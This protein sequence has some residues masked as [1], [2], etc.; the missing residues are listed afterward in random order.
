MK[1]LLH[2]DDVAGTKYGTIG[3][4]DAWQAGR[5]DGFSVFANG[6][7]M[8]EFQTRLARCPNE[9][10]IM[11]H[12]NLSEGPSSAAAETVPL[13]V[14]EKGELKHGFG[15]LLVSWMTG[16]SSNR[17]KL[18]IQIENEWRA[19]I[20]G[21]ADAISPRQLSGVDGHI[22]IHMLPFLFPIAAR[23]ANEFSLG[24][25][26]V[27]REPFH[28]ATNE[29]GNALL[30]KAFNVFK[31]LILRACAK[32]ATAVAIKHGLHFPARVVGVL[33]SGAMTKAAALSAIS[34]S[35]KE[36]A[37]DIELIFHVG[38]ATPEEIGRWSGR[39]AIAEFNIASARDLE[40]KE[41]VELHAALVAKGKRNGI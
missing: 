23:L 37:A 19:Q 33:Y 8:D 29:H 38:R 1:I 24:S 6:D 5:L 12:L 21:V 13:L 14:D 18:E 4:M 35:E 20:K 11:A 36:A 32:S 2:A 9:A 7:A 34:L 25:I 17:R 27:T 16:S 26:R 3:I 41:L 28:R 15:S 31:H 10:R 40:S 39:Q 30:P 22:H